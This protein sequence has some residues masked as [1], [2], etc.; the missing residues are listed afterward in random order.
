MTAGPWTQDKEDTLV[1]MWRERPCLFAVSSPE[2]SDRNKR[3][4]ALEEMAARL[5]ISGT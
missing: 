3:Q 2:Y 5:D 4:V 1:D